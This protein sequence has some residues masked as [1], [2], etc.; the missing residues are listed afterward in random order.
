MPIGV[1][2]E[3]KVLEYRVGL[4]PDSVREF[5]MH[6]HNVLVET[7]AGAGIGCSD[8]DYHA[9]GAEIV[10]STREVLDKVEMIVKV[11]EPQAPEREMPKVGQVLFAYLHRHRIRSRQETSSTAEPFA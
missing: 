8:A 7:Q 1:P 5:V 6:G 9:A 11:K 10:G 2:K 4:T 3:I